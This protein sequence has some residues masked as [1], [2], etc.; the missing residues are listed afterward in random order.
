MTLFLLK[1]ALQVLK[2]KANKEHLS[3]EIK[4]DIK[5]INYIS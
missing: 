5:K 1:I 4:F 2:T 3:I